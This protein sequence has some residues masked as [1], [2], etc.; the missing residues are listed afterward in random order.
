LY[1]NLEILNKIL[2]YLKKVTGK[3]QAQIEV[4]A[5]YAEK[6]ISGMKSRGGNLQPIIEQL[7]LVYG[8][9]LENTT[10]FDEYFNNKPDSNSIKND[11]VKT[12][13]LTERLDKKNTSINKKTIP[14]Y[15]AEAVGGKTDVDMI[16]I[17]DPN[18]SIDVGDLLSDS[19]AAIRIFGNSMLPNYPSGCVVGL[20]RHTESFIVPGEIYVVETVNA[21]LLKRL[22]Y[23]DD[24]PESD[25]VTCISDNTMVFDCGAR[26]GKLAYPAFDI[27]LAE[28]IKLYIVTGVIKRNTNSLVINKK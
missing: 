26:K 9:E 11:V 18:N 6:Y 17:T 16:P 4:G 3:T 12:N 5:N 15:D 1:N 22:F 27:P 10:F 20:V 8:K 28:V 14:F 25:K 24:N 7:F 2:V 21:R 23:K 13:Y 19:E